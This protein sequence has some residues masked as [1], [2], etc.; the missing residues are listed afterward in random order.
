MFL[1]LIHKENALFSFYSFFYVFYF[2][3]NK[4]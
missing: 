3:Y 2:F 1:F 4:F